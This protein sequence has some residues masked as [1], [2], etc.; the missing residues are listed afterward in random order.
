MYILRSV[1]APALLARLSDPKPIPFPENI[2]TDVDDDAGYVRNAVAEDCGA[3][4]D[5]EKGDGGAT[6]GGAACIGI[7]FVVLGLIL[8]HDRAMR[9]GESREPSAA[10]LRFR[11]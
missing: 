6:G 10:L 9:D 7:L 11:C 5:W 3:V 4:L 1:L 2:P 8:V